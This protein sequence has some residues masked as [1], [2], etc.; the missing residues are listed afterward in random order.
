M[1]DMVDTLHTPPPAPEP[2]RRRIPWWGILAAVVA[3]LACG[4]LFIATVNP[5][6]TAVVTLAETIFR[7]DRVAPNQIV[8]CEL[9]SACSTI[10]ATMRGTWRVRATASAK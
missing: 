4:A 3:L 7:Y 9:N 5:V 6:F 1:A 2:H 8:Q 10:H